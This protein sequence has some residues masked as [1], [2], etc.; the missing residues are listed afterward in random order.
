MTLREREEIRA[1]SNETT[2]SQHQ[3]NQAPPGRLVAV[4]TT[5]LDEP[6]GLTHAGL[7]AGACRRG[8]PPESSASETRERVEGFVIVAISCARTVGVSVAGGGR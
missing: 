6:L 3:Q 7:A 4:F 5:L 8:L 1:G 2:P